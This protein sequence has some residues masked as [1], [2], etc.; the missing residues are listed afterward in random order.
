MYLPSL[1]LRGAYTFNDTIDLTSY[2][3]I[4]RGTFDISPISFTSQVFKS[5]YSGNLYNMINLYSISFNCTSSYLTLSISMDDDSYIN[6]EFPF[7]SS[8]Y[9]STLANAVE[10]S[11][12]IYS[13]QNFIENF[14]F[15]FNEEYFLTEEQFDIFSIFFSKSGN[16]YVQFYKGY[17]HYNNGNWVNSNYHFNYSSPLFMTNS[18][19]F[20][21]YQHLFEDSDVFM[22]INTTFDYSTNVYFYKDSKY[23]TNTNIN[24][25]GLL[26]RYV[27]DCMNYEGV[28]QFIDDTPN[29]TWYE[30]ILSVM[31]APIYFLKNLLG[32]ELFGI[33]LFVALGSLLTL[34][35]ILVIVKKV[36]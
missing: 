6:F 30:M 31:D 24:I 36:I 14:V 20:S 19:M 7:N 25:Q 23:L 4:P 16:R 13:N 28:F 15:V 27:R 18:N 1:V 9:V 33:S 10:Q 11:A 29:S 32:F 17:Y 12:V 26:P 3:S 22:S 21:S 35:L 5:N 2:S 34:V 8:Y